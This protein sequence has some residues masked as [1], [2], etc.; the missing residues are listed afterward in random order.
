MKILSVL[1]SP[2]E[3][4]FIE[5]LCTI[6]K[7]LG[8]NLPSG[9]SL[10]SL[11]KFSFSTAF[12]PLEFRLLYAQVEGIQIRSEGGFVY[13]SIPNGE[14]LLRSRLAFLLEHSHLAAIPEPTPPKTGYAFYRG[15]P[16]ILLGT[17]N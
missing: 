16:Q 8:E 1:S 7:S 10:F 17:V 4:N 9:I 3:S 2:E 14:H 11:K 6:G 15:S 5:Q 13:C 12:K